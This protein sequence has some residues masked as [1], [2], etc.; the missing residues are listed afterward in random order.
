VKN[1]S[2]CQTRNVGWGYELAFLALTISLIAF[3]TA[4]PA[5]TSTD[6]KHGDDSTTTV[7]V[8]GQTVAI[9]RQTGKLRP[10]TPE[11]AKALAAGLK[12]ML[13]RSTEGLTAVRHPNGAVTVDLQGRFQSVAV[14]TKNPDG[15]V[16]ESCVTSKKE[17]SAFLKSAGAGAAK[18]S[19]AKRNSFRRMKATD[20]TERGN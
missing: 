13:N 11:E 3:S 9:D 18:S 4:A 16:A 7:H 10:P 1:L 14:A 17:A 20:K 5:Q 6:T 2:K 12:N 8:A 15:T 19:V